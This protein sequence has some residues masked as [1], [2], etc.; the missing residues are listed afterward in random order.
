MPARSH[1]SVQR[2]GLPQAPS[3]RMA[4]MR[5]AAFEVVLAHYVQGFAAAG[6]TQEVISA[7]TEGQKHRFRRGAES[8]DLAL[9]RRPGGLLELRLQGPTH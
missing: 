9:Q 5:R 2:L 4:G 8:I 3:M 6:Y 1:F 7:N